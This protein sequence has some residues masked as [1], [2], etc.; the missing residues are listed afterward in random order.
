MND[1]N[2][3]S[4]PITPIPE[5]P[6]LTIEALAQAHQSLRAAFHVT[7]VMVVVLSG[8][9]FVF[10]LR[11]VSL[12]RRQI[13]ELTQ[14]VGDYQQNVL[15]RMEAFRA[16]LEAFTRTHPDFA[17]IYTRYFGTNA[18][19]LTQA[20]GRPKPAPANPNAARMPPPH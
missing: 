11:E 16:G 6:Q 5:A 10:F 13:V 17:P 1:L 7:L 20:P 18:T 14:I 3:S 4:S 15:P 19:P 8:A 9:L 2:D 12:A